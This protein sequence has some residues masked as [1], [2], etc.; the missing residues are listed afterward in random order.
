MDYCI[1][2]AVEGLVVLDKC[3]FF[4]FGLIG[5][6]IKLSDIDTFST[7]CYTVLHSGVCHWL[8]LQFHL[9]KI[10]ETFFCF[11]LLVIITFLNF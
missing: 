7:V 6:K 4:F 3:G 1:P 9:T 5:P 10:K 11:L 2:E 8:E